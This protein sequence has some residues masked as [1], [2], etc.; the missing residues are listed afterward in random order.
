MVTE[1]RHT[2][3]MKVPLQLQ[4]EVTEVLKASDERWSS[5][6]QCFMRLLLHWTQH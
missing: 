4:I 1:S 2:P 5:L 3:A 6:L